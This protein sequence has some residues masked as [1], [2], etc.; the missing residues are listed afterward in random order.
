MEASKSIENLDRLKKQRD[1]LP[2]YLQFKVYVDED[3]KEVK[4]IDNVKTL[5]NISNGNSIVTKGQ[6]RSVEH[7][8]K[9][10]RG[11]LVPRNSFNCW[12]LLKRIIS[13]QAHDGKVQRLMYMVHSSEW[14]QG[15]S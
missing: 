10:G 3:G 15:A 8:E 11:I 5:K 14:K 12:K 7:A 2:K 6:A 1:L 9:I 4:G 13:S